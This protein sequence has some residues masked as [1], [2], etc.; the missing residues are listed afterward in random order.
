[1][2][3]PKDV[4]LGAGFVWVVYH[5]D[6]N[7]DSLMVLPSKASPLECDEGTFSFGLAPDMSQTRGSLIWRPDPPKKERKR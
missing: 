6:C 5:S 3:K 1:M 2:S 4:V 7:R